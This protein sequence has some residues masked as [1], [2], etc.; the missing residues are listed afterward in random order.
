MGA[1]GNTHD[2]IRTGFCVARFDLR[3]E[4]RPPLRQAL[5]G[6]CLRP[7]TENCLAWRGEF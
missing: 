3:V 1:G 7:E 6:T 4:A 5:E 2:D